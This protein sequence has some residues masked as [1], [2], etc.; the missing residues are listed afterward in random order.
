M[1]VELWND[2]EATE[3]KFVADGEWMNTDD[4]GYCDEDGQLWFKSRADDLI[5]T[6]G[7]RVGPAEVEDSIRELDQVREVGIIGVEDDGRGEII[8]AYIEPSEGGRRR[9]AQR[10][11][12]ITRQDQPREVRVS[13]RD[14]VH[15]R[16]ADHRHRQDQTNETRG[17]RA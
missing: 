16:G 6:N 11:G 14:H 5:I 17:T 3:R 9:P 12:S 8:K 1:L 4:L 10:S 13:S 15:R 2:D 7:Y